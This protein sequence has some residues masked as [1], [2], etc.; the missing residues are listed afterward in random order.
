MRSPATDPI[1]G[2]AYLGLCLAAALVGLIT[3]VGVWLFMQGFGLINRL[4]LG[5]VWLRAGAGRGHRYRRDPRAGWAHRRAVHAP[6]S[7]PD[8][9]ARWRT[10]R[11]RGGAG[12][13]P[14]LSQRRRIYS[15]S[16]LGI[17]F[18]A[19]VGAD[20]PAAMIGGHFGSWL[21]QRFRWPPVFIRVLVVAGAGA[22]I[23]ATYFAQL[24]AVFFALEVVLGG[25][26]GALFAVPTLLAVVVSVLFSFSWAAC[27]CNTRFGRRGPLGSGAAARISAWRCWRPWLPSSTSIC[28][29]A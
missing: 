13:A 29:R 5:T 27:R 25:F 11:R 8:R 3:S 12:R 14:Q 10:H 19:P 4:T 2:R 7:R 20:T 17:G 24:A 28:C 23:S 22:G 26:G 15:G 6:P 21:A 1:S 9:L 18:G 16:M